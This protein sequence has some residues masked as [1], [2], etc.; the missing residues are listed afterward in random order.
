MVTKIC[1]V[2]LSSSL[3]RINL[4]KIFK[5]DR[6]RTHILSPEA[7]DY[8]MKYFLSS[9]CFGTQNC[10][11]KL[12]WDKKFSE[13]DCF[14]RTCENSKWNW[15]NVFQIITV[16][17]FMYILKLLY[18]NILL[19]YMCNILLLCNLD[20]MWISLCTSPW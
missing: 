15:D 8:E 13:E 10:C 1:S 11:T 20:F 16:L 14:R 7:N 5:V 4:A 2:M 17:Y 9:L 3:R 12:Q 18:I 19:V 6:V